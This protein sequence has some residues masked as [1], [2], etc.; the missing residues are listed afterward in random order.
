LSFK[1]ASS[2]QIL[3]D[4]QARTAP[5]ISLGKRLE[6]YQNEVTMLAPSVSLNPAAIELSLC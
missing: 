5:T 2:D 6:A 4:F 1:V 3:A